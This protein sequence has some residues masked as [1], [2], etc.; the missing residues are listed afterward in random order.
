ML[1]KKIR[2]EEQGKNLSSGEKSRMTLF[3]ALIGSPEVLILDEPEN[4]L[5]EKGYQIIKYLLNHYE[6][7]IIMATHCSELIDLCDS[8]WNLDEFSIKSKPDTIKNE[9]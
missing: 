3:R 5:D 1:M 6:G 7:T 2:I 9:I 8:M 4:H